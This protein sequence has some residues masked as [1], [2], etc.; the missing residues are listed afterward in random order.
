MNRFQK[1]FVLLFFLTFSTGFAQFDFEF[2]G[3]IQ[4][5]PIYQITEKKLAS[6]LNLE[7]SQFLNLTRIRIRP[8]FY[9]WSRGRLNI[10]YEISTLYLNNEG[11]LFISQPEKS[12]RQIVDLTWTPINEK[13]FIFQESNL[14][15]KYF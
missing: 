14:A 5:L 3:Y 1:L 13:N 4:D 2:S 12:A 15:L 7:E 8:T 9:L 6:L 11:N 10:E